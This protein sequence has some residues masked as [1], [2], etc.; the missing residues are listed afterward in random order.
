MTTNFNFLKTDPQFATFADTAIQAELV[1]PISPSFSA[2]GSR[3]ALEFAVKW[4]YSVDNSLE[5][6][7]EDK[8]VTLINTE[9]F[10][11]LLPH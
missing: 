5:K 3:T 6:P 4:L 9:D 11:D 8:L 1:L 7:Y 2:T 10:K